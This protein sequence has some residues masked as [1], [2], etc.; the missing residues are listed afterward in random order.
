M[1]S[2]VPGG[3]GRGAKSRHHRLLLLA[4]SSRRLL[5]S[6]ALP[7]PCCWR[8]DTSEGMAG[9]EGEGRA[10]GRGG[11]EERETAAGR[12]IREVT[13]KPKA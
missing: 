3:R 4:F 7:F 11:R 8:A 12:G 5:I 13:L 6:R 10:N 2:L 1:C 9:G